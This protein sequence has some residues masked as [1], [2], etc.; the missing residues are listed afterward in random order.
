MNQDGRTIVIEAFVAKIT[1]YAKETR[2]IG[3]FS[4]ML[5]ADDGA[6][7]FSG[8]TVGCKG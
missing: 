6:Y 2:S 3:R 7:A 1:H 4:S 8:G 5:P